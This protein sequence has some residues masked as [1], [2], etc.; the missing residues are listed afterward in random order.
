MVPAVGEDCASHVAGMS[1]VIGRAHDHLTP[2][3]R[4]FIEGNELVPTDWIVLP[5]QAKQWHRYLVDPSTHTDI[6]IVVR[7]IFIS[8]HLNVLFFYGYHAYL[9]GFQNFSETLVVA[10]RHELFHQG[11]LLLLDILVQI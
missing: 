3:R 5:M 10:V 6:M 2:L 8:V 9:I 4:D 7:S 11:Q 1:T